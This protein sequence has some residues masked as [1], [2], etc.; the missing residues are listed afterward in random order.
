MK[1][2]PHVFDDTAEVYTPIKKRLTCSNS[3]YHA[4]NELW[5]VVNL[6]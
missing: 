5:D 2:V 4:P 6:E 3:V 1:T